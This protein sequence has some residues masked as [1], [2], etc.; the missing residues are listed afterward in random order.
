MSEFTRS[1]RSAVFRKRKSFGRAAG[2]ALAHQG[3]NGDDYIDVGVENIV[4][5]GGWPP[6]THE[7]FRA[8]PARKICENFKIVM[9]KNGKA[10]FTFAVK[11]FYDKNPSRRKIFA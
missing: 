7:I 4:A 10:E 6:Q 1:A 3:V 11:P 9:P 8:R 5:R 2:K